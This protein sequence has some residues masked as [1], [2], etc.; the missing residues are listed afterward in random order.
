MAKKEDYMARAD[1]MYK[2]DGYTVYLENGQKLFCGNF[3]HGNI[4]KNDDNEKHNLLF[5]YESANMEMLPVL[6]KEYFDK[7][8]DTKTLEFI[9]DADTETMPNLAILEK[10]LY[11]LHPYFQLNKREV[12]AKAICDYFNDLVISIYGDSGFTGLDDVISVIRQEGSEENLHEECYGDLTDAEIEAK[13]LENEPSLIDENAMKAWYSYALSQLTGFSDDNGEIFEIIENGFDE[14]FRNFLLVS[15]GELDIN[16]FKLGGFKDEIIKQDIFKQMLFWIFDLSAPAFGELPIQ[17]RAWLY[18]RMFEK[19]SYLYKMEASQELTLSPLFEEKTEGKDFFDEIRERLTDE[20]KSDMGLFGYHLNPDNIPQEILA[21]LQ[22]VADYAKGLPTENIPE[23]YR[24]NGL[25]HLLFLEILQMVKAET[26]IKRCKLCG[27][28][29]EVTNLNMEYCNRTWYSKGEE[30]SVGWGTIKPSVASTE[31]KILDE[32]GKV[33]YISETNNLAH[34]MSELLRTGKLGNNDR[35]PCSAIGSR[36]ISKQK[37]KEDIPL[38]IY[39]RAYKK[40]YA[41]QKNK[42]LDSSDF[43]KWSKDAK[44][45][46]DAFRDGKLGISIEEFEILINN[47]K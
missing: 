36:L 47:I 9:C 30:K 26:K 10:K 5:Y 39:D 2:N 13:V 45:N 43:T 11:E 22:S 46:L 14:L 31:Y 12:V 25:G 7:K 40:Y 15:Q 32:R 21:T 35:L 42:S 18:Y 23:K 4:F 16:H 37:K 3:Q 1:V 19:Y 33:S 38:Q 20:T 44:N 17:L 24:I 27:M 6:L 28:Y 29:F 8:L 41:R 34:R